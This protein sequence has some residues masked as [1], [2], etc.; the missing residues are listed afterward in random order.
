MQFL[1]WSDQYKT[2]IPGIDREHRELFSYVKNFSEA[3]VDASSRDK[4]AD[5]LEFLVNYTRQHFSAEEVLMKRVAYPR[6]DEHRAAHE[7]LIDKIA[8]LVRD[9]QSETEIHPEQVSDFL[10]EWWSRHVLEEDFGYIPWVSSKTG[11]R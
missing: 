11:P 1:Q 9:F 8:G 6:F 2:G 3:A 7:A 4:M 5:L 10:T